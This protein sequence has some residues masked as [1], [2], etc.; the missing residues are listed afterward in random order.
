MCV[1]PRKQPAISIFSMMAVD[2]VGA[3]V[4]TADA[5]EFPVAT[6][7]GGFERQKRDVNTLTMALPMM[8]YAL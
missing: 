6:D 3:A 4:T 2:M 5:F 1:M 8:A 7:A